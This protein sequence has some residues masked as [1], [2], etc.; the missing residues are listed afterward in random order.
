MTA[1]LREWIRYLLCAIDGHKGVRHVGR[2]LWQCKSCGRK[3]S[4]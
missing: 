4:W 2:N 3:F 1:K